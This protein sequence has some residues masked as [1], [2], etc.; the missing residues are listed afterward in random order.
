MCARAVVFKAVVS[1]SIV[2][3]N[4]ARHIRY[5]FEPEIMA[6]LEALAWWR[7]ADEIEKAVPFIMNADIQGFLKRYETE[8]VERSLSRG[9]SQH[10]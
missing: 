5:R 10:V 4:P 6:R 9:G 7:P 3:G 1:Y 8:S 2:A